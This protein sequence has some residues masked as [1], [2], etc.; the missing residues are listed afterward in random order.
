MSQDSLMCYVQHLQDYQTRYAYLDNRLD[1]A[2]WLKGKFE[3]FGYAS[4]ELD[5]VDWEG[6]HQYNVIAKLT[7]SVYPDSYVK[8]FA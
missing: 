1:F 3:S 5:S 2:N 6:D 7:G 8:T 4:A